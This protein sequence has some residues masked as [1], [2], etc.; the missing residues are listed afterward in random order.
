MASP[1]Q[2]PGE[3]IIIDDS[4]ESDAPRPGRKQSRAKR[5][6]NAKSAPFADSSNPQKARVST[7][8]GHFSNSQG[9]EEGEVDE[10]GDRARGSKP[11]MA[12]EDVMPK[13]PG[14][15]SGP[16]L[17]A[18]AASA[19]NTMSVVMHPDPPMWING[20]HSF[21]LPAFSAQREGSWL[22]RFN[23][24]VHLFYHHNPHHGVA[25]TSSLVLG[26][27]T[28]YLDNISGLKSGKRKSGKKA[29]QAAEKS[30][31]LAKNL[32]K[33]RAAAPRSQTASTGTPVLASGVTRQVSVVADHRRPKQAPKNSGRLAE[34]GQPS[35][36]GDEQPPKDTSGEKLE[37]TD[38]EGADCFLCGSTDPG[39]V[40][41]DCRDHWARVYP[42]DGMLKKVVDLPITCAI[43]ASREHFLSECSERVHPANPTWSLANR[44]RFI[45]PDCGVL[46]IEDA[47]RQRE[48]LENPP[49]PQTRMRGPMTRASN[50]HYSESDDTDIE[51]LGNRIV[52]QQSSVGQ[53]RIS[54]NIMARNASHSNQSTTLQP[55]QPTG[56]PSGPAQSQPPFGGRGQRRPNPQ[57]RAPGTS[58]PDKPPP[59]SRGYHGVAPPPALSGSYGRGGTNG[60]GRSGPGK[61]AGHGGRGRSKGR[62]R[63]RAK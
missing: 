20:S 4:S 35:L 56:L 19:D 59:P 40:E 11:T 61:R 3:I 8:S 1:A 18:A 55:P 41:D 47:M 24:W 57:P 23:D 5:A 52:R 14:Q 39:H 29:A 50:V 28:Y 31:V 10:S 37:L 63:G 7:A 27:Y 30:G 48:G 9:S 13:Q 36:G 38:G 12:G 15:D 34:S 44:S 46:C 54:T 62:G 43:C 2:I 42:P 33:L 22:A 51:F 25:F 60:N 16:S 58:L 32:K 26:G 21:K 53:M 17:T 6:K 45:D 49:V